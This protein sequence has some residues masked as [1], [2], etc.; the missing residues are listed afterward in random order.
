MPDFL[1]TS[2]LADWFGISPVALLLVGGVFVWLIRRLGKHENECA[3]YRKE[4]RGELRELRDGI[5]NVKASI[6]RIE[7]SMKK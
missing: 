2:H 1:T 4:M 3:L 5:H 6:A 7:G